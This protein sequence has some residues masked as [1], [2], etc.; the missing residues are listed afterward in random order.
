LLGCHLSPPT[1]GL[2]TSDVQ[3]QLPREVLPTNQLKGKASASATRNE[4][5]S[6]SIGA[7]IGVDKN[8]WLYLINLVEGGPAA[9]SGA[10]LHGDRLVGI[11][12]TP[13][14]PEFAMVHTLTKAQVINLIQGPEGSQLTLWIVRD[15]QSH[16][17]TLT[18]AVLSPPE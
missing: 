12:T 9:N 6:A 11:K 13:E 15:F 7:S 4:G 17:V 2:Q 3:I 8:G 1:K 16:Y 14:T 5:R 10:I 18:R